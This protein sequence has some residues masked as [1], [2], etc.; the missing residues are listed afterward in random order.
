VN[1]GEERILQVGATN[2]GRV[3]LVVTTWRKGMI[4]VVTA[5]PAPKQLRELY[6]RNTP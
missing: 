6:L 3:L 5:Y 1:D 2:K 4:R